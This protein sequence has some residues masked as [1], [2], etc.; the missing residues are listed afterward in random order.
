MNENRE[1]GIVST[2]GLLSDVRKTVFW[3][4]FAL[5]MTA[6]GF[7]FIDV[8]RFLSVMTII[9][10][11]ILINFEGLF[12][13]STLILLATLLIVYFSPLGKIKIGGR[14]AEPLLSKWRWFSITLCT[15]LAT[16]ILFWA[17]AEPMYH[18]YTPPES[19]N[20]IPGTA[21]AREFTMATMFMHWSFS[22]Y[23]IYCVPSL[24]FALCYYNLNNPFTIGSTLT[25]AIG[26]T[27]VSYGS[28]VIDSIALFALVTGMASS[29][30]TGILTLSGGIEARLGI[31]NGKVL[32]AIVAI[33]I[34]LSFVMSA[35][36]GLHKG[37]ARLSNVN[38]QVFLIF[39]IFVFVFGPTGFI[40][41]NGIS[42]LTEYG[43]S[44]FERSTNQL[45]A[46]DDDWTRSWTVFY[47]A[48]WYAWA[49]IAALFLGRIAKGYTVRQFIQINL[50]LPACCAI[51]WMSTFSGAAIHFDTLL[52]GAFQQSLLNNGPESVIYML[53]D[54]LPFTSLMTLALIG[55]T[56]ISFVTAADSNTDAMS[57]LCTKSN[58]EQSDSNRTSMKLKF[59]WGITIGVIA[60]VMV[61][62]AS[63]DGI[64]MLTSLGGLPALFIIITTNI[65]LFV[66]LKRAIQGDS[67]QPERE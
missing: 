12:S 61:S 48:N 50:I 46:P 51:L 2:T 41:S 21:V 23:A 3:P 11:W 34:V 55:I 43:V 35:V 40:L 28:S 47:F 36:S 33:L 14:D 1:D 52:G 7:S 24:V 49:P 9:N 5:L 64:R 22:P 57:R 25:P 8:E 29:L 58:L 31:P 65:S 4:S 45:T 19:L 10:N 27:A 42:G 62:F 63:I 37:I 44:F 13:Y 54:N 30:G 53:F 17:V 32:M 20:L 26:K 18:L 15:T 56:F 6:V 59:V 66:L 38:A 67:F 60:W 39:C 16:G